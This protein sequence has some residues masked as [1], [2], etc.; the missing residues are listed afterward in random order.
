VRRP[1]RILLNAGTAASLL[2]SAA[3]AL[4]WA[5]SHHLEDWVS[6]TWTSGLWDV[7]TSQGVLSIYW[8]RIVDPA[9]SYRDDE[10]NPHG[11]HHTSLS[12]PAG[13]HVV[14]TRPGGNDVDLH[15][16]AFRFAVH[17]GAADPWPS[18]IKCI[19]LPLWS[20]AA[21]FLILPAART[22]GALRRRASRPP[23][24]GLCP[25]CRYDLRATPDRCPE[26]GMI[27]PR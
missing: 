1:S 6:R 25:A 11:I 10:D 20:L 4:V 12:P 3:T 13:A 21:A 18:I 7:R 15:C 17:D 16:G 22:A 2:V 19:T 9:A 14:L 8:E 27:P 26:C 23:A 24:A 5:R